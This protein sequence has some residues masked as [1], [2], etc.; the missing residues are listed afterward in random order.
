MSNNNRRSFLKSVGLGSGA[1]FFSPDLGVMNSRELIENKLNAEGLGIYRTT[2][3]T[4]DVCVVGGGISGICAAIAAARNGS[5][6]VLIHDRSNL[7]GNASSEI[8]MHISGSSVLR[9]VWREI[10]ILEEMVLDDAVMN[11]Q[12]AYPLWDFVMYNKV[13]S[14]PNITLLLD[15]MMYDADYKNNTIESVRAFSS[16]TEEIFIIKASHF[17]DCTGDGTL[18]AVVGAEYMRGRE[19]KSK[20]NESLGQDVADEV[21]MGN[22]LLFMAEKMDRPMPFTPPEWARKYTF[23]D[24]EFRRIHS[25]EYGYWWLELAGEYDIINDGRELRHQLLAVLF[26]VWD[27]IKNS[28]NHEDSENWALTWVGMVPGKRE[29]RR[30]VG[31]VIMTQRDTQDPQ[32]Y[33]DR[34]AYG[35]WSL[36]DHPAEGMDDTSI[37]PNRSVG[38]KK[39]YSIPL[40]SLYSKN[41]KNLWMAG[42]NISVSHVALSSSRVMATCSTLGQAVGSAMSYCLEKSISARELAT[43]DRYLKDYQQRMVRQDQSILNV[44]NEDPKDLARK[45]TVSASAETTDGPANA[46]IDGINRNVEDGKTHQWQAEMNGGQPW[47]ELKWSSP[48]T[49][50]TVEFTFDTGL[51]R[52]LRISGQA[53][54]MKG[55]VRGPQPETISDYKIEGLLNGR[56][57]HTEFASGNYYRKVSHVFDS[58]R[59]DALRLTVIKTNGDELARLF[60]IRCYNETARG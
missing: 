45:S 50:N 4:V 17:A 57:V 6:V 36:D 58:I 47:I 27:Y 29:S 53:V 54:V 20:W 39:P 10:G 56:V 25:I 3:M 12:V 40:R 30:I 15:T 31:D 60:E 18:A 41:I 38:L 22:S 28:G 21:G 11:P 46:V 5:K 2:E 51:H 7:G 19:A 35:G 23:K 1:L 43:T 42:R 33:P 48:Q 37:K 8:R 26:G 34:V 59:I 13:Y 55:Q 16:Q 24:F 52:F 44:P 32:N 14:E 9:T 49:I